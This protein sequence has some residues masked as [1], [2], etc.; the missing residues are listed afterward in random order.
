MEKQEYEML[1]MKNY[2]FSIFDYIAYL[3]VFLIF[4]IF[5]SKKET[6]KIEKKVKDLYNSISSED[7]K[8][9]KEII[10]NEFDDDIKKV[11]E[12]YYHVN[13]N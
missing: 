2:Q 7:F 8:K 4:V 5:N 13:K 9:F 11:Q 1:I 3:S 10:K 6:I 12:C